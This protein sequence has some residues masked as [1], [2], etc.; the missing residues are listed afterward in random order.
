MV[1]ATRP[2]GPIYGV[3]WFASV[4]QLLLHGPNE[5]VTML[6]HYPSRG[7]NLH[8]ITIAKTRCGL[9]VLHGVRC[10]CYPHKAWDV[11]TRFDTT[12]ATTRQV[13]VM[14]NLP[15]EKLDNPEIRLLEKYPFRCV[16]RMRTNVIHVFTN[17][18]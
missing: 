18:N 12:A 5:G 6:V 9:T 3:P 13:F 1:L 10:F 4:V 7:T 14:F 17:V 15:S 16:A 2:V 8:T 11:N